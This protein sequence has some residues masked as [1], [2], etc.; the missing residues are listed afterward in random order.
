MPSY[1][2]MGHHSFNLVRESALSKFAGVILS[3]VNDSLDVMK[4]S[5]E[6]IPD[7]L[8]DIVFD[9]QLYF[10]RSNRGHLRD[11]SYYP[12]D[13]GTADI[14]SESWWNPIHRSLIDITSELGVTSLCSPAIVPRTYSDDYYDVMVKA[15]N[16]LVASATD[17]QVLQTAVVNLAELAVPDRVHAIASILSRTQAGRIYLVLVTDVEPRRELQD[18]EGLKGAMRLI[19]LLR[20]ADL[21]VLVGYTSSDMIL[22]K[23]AGANA[24]ATGKFFNVRRFTSSRWEEPSEGG[25]QLPYWFQDY[26]FGFFRESDVLRLRR[27]G[28]L[29]NDGYTNPFSSRILEVFEEEPGSAWLGLSWRQYLYEF[30]DLEARIDTGQVDIPRMLR[31]AERIWLEFEDNNIF[32]EEPRNDGSWLRSWLI[33]VSEHNTND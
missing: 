17:V 3:P 8:S 12:L 33:A 13:Y 20:Q 22:W 21:E 5:L 29:P 9:P 11:W 7:R 4:P 25:S 16:R 27:Y 32:M 18:T 26:L 14:G 15:G 24:C 28:Q 30:A 10:P 1:H 6:S 2:Q 31:T 19:S 23:F